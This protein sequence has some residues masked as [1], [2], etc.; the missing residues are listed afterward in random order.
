MSIEKHGCNEC[1]IVNEYDT[2]TKE[3]QSAL[4][5]YLLSGLCEKCRGVV[6]SEMSDTS[7]RVLTRIADT[8]DSI[9]EILT[10]KYK[11]E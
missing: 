1:G 9:L 11:G 3:G 7:T 6:L 5:F 10:I 8:L 2:D 4:S